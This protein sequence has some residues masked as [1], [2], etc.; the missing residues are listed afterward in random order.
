MSRNKHRVVPGQP[1]PVVVDA[2]TWSPKIGDHVAWIYRSTDRSQY[3]FCDDAAKFTFRI[4]DGCVFAVDG[5]SAT[6][7][8]R[9]FFGGL[10]IV[11]IEELYPS[12][13]HA[14]EFLHSIPRCVAP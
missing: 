12:P 6:I 10:E 2:A 13:S 4:F 9:S 5:V 1:S 8:V 14:R 11:K 7:Q 3:S